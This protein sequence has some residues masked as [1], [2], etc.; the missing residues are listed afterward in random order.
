MN[1]VYL[2]Y[3]NEEYFIDEYIKKL[4]EKYSDYEFVEYDMLETNISDVIESANMESLFCN[5]KIILCKNSYFLTSKKC[6]IDH[7]IEELITYI[8]HENSNIM[9]LSLNEDGIDKRKKVV[10]EL[11]KASN[12]NKYNKIKGIELEKFIINYCKDNKYEIDNNALK[13]IIELVGDNLFI[14]INELNKIFI[15]KDKDNKINI[16]DVNIGVSR[17][18]N[19]NIFDFIDAIVKNDKS[20]ALKL[21]DDLIIM[22]EEEIKL[23]VILANQFRLIY[24][25]KKMYSKGYS[26]YDISKELGIHPYRIKLA[27]NID[28]KCDVILNIIKKLSLLDQ[29]IKTGVIQ[30]DIAL[31]N[32]ILEL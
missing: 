22:N 14:I 32:F 27:N 9:I 25:V 31:K 23:I 16:E 15:Y 2:V 11:E 26:E 3:G 12:I 24:Q 29:N 17:T 28:I 18:I 21:Y 30:K 5:N 20:I 19:N 4:L 6:D 7:K 8:N 13:K 1:N 10:K